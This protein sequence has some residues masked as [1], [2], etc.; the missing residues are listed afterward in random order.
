MKASPIE[1]INT[2]SPYF[3]EEVNSY[4]IR[5]EP[6]TLIDTGIGTEEAWTALGRGLEDVGL[7]IEEIQQVVLTHRHPD[8]FG[9]ARR[10]QRVSGARVFIH[11][12]ERDFILRFV[13]DYDHWVSTIVDRLRG[14]G[15]PQEVIQ[16]TRPALQATE[17]MAESVEAESLVEGQ[18]LPVSG[19]DLEV[20]H[21]PG[22]TLGSICL[23]YGSA[24]LT[25]DHVLP[26]Y[27]PNIGGSDHGEIG[28]LQQFLDSLERVRSVSSEGLEVLPGHGPP[29]S[30]LAARVDFMVEHHRLRSQAILGI[31]SDKDGQSNWDV[32]SRLFGE[33][34]GIHVLLGLG[35]VDAHFEYLEDQGQTRSSGGAHSLA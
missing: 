7:R 9:L 11:A 6:L 20:L 16:E 21:T 24:L 1:C 19:V 4:V 13:E 35:E 23:R 34:Q 27:T 18:R 30:D 8:H 32:A 31:L 14:W 12:S 26:Q 22:H 5:G 15:A 17:D 25:G 3:E 29:I 28:I 10:I 33:L 2:P